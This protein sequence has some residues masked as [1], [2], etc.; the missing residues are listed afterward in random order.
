MHYVSSTSKDWVSKTSLSKY[1]QLLDQLVEEENW[2]FPNSFSS[3][4]LGSKSHTDTL[5]IVDFSGI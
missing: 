5:T 1:D 2:P 4:F 3:I